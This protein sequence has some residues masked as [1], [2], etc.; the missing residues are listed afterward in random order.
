MNPT[1]PAWSQPC[2]WQMARFGGTV[3]TV[4]RHGW[5]RFGGTVPNRE[6]IKR[7]GPRDARG[8]ALPLRASEVGITFC[9]PHQPAA[10][11]PNADKLFGLISL[12]RGQ[13]FCPAQAENLDGI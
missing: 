12:T 2:Q 7:S 8:P 9:I 5:A 11:G 4:R 13:I 10:E 1:V 6:V 3:G